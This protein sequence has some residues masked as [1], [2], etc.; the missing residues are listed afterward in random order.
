MRRNVIASLVCAAAFIAAPWV[1]ADVVLG[2]PRAISTSTGEWTWTYIQLDVPEYVNP[3]AGT[4]DDSVYATTGTT[5]TSIAGA[6]GIY[7]GPTWGTWN[8]TFSGGNQPKWLND[9][10][11]WISPYSD[12][13]G[14]A[15]VNGFYAYKYDITAPNS[16]GWFTLRLDMQAD[17]YITAVYLNGLTIWG[18]VEDADIH[19]GQSMVQDWTGTLNLGG[20]SLGEQKYDLAEYLLDD[21]TLSLIF[22]VHNTGQGS[23][24]DANPTGLYVSGRYAFGTDAIENSTPEPATLLILGIG[25]SGLGVARLRRRR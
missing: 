15:S 22:V 9:G 19:A 10:K 25:L 2:D 4:E 8:S 23:I 18:A 11:G 7:E 21:L 5:W 6:S 20:F 1:K 3:V 13:T 14:N 12:S 16:D 24:N 17:D